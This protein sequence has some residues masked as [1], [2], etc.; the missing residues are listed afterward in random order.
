MIGPL[1]DI[2]DVMHVR[3]DAKPD[4]NGTPVQE[5][6]V[7]RVL[8]DHELSQGMMVDLR[9]PR[10]RSPN[11]PNSSLAVTPRLTR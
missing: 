10:Q 3:I 9:G 1:A 2:T 11:G 4:R 8:T 6:M 7:G 5:P